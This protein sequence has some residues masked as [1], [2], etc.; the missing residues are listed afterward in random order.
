M[1]VGEL[2]ITAHHTPGHTPGGATWSWRS[3][4]GDRCL[5]IVY[6]DSLTAVSAPGYRFSDAPEYVEAFRSTLDK[7]RG[8]PCDVLL[9][10][11]PVSSGLD[12]KIEGRANGVKPDP[13][14]DSDACRAYADAATKT[15]ERRLAE[16]R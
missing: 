1:T 4:E 5:N 16:E 12:G 7:V 10:T 3:C 11:H 8:L 6:A 14:I 2:Q 13:F 9:S 15:L